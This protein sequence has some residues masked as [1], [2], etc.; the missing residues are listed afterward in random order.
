MREQVTR[1][2]E[3]NKS[4]GLL[5]QEKC[6][7][8]HWMWVKRFE[9][10]TNIVQKEHEI[11]LTKERVNVPP[12]QKKQTCSKVIGYRVCETLSEAI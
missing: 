7:G 6:L 4:M 3:S 9:R 5:A 10:I 8:Q 11:S 1:V 2:F 12:E